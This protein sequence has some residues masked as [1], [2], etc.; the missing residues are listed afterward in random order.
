MSLNQTETNPSIPFRF[1]PAELSG[2]LGDLGTFLPLVIAM[3]ITFQDRGEYLD[4]GVILFFAGLMNLLSGFVF[5]QPI[6]VQP[7]K[8]IAAVAIA[9]G[10]TTGELAASGILMGV[11]LVIV[12]LSGTIDTITKWIPRPIVRG[13]QL[14]VGLKLGFK[15]AQMIAGLEVGGWDGRI[16][17]AVIAV[18]LLIMMWKRIPGLLIMFVAG[19]GILFISNQQAFHHLT[20]SWPDFQFIVPSWAEWRGGFEKGTLPQLPLTLLNSVVAVCALSG[21]YFPKH[22]IPPRRMALSVGMMNLI[23]C[24]FGGMP[25][26]HGSGGLAAQY[27]FGA[28]TGASVIML[29]I[30]KMVVG[31]FLGS[32]ILQLLSAYPQSIIAIMLIVAGVGL[33]KAARDCLAGEAFFIVFMTAVFSLQPNNTA[34]GFLAGIITFLALKLRKRFIALRI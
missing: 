34:L 16:V 28:R 10:L 12:A 25:M 2:S 32:A 1:S 29:G 9:D 17:G 14:G 26:C 3:V 13:I 24:P 5:R 30:S 8:A 6:P 33:A 21:D 11:I 18:A 7:M 15:G 22:A 27:E 31:L 20:F 23:A 19:F 4:L